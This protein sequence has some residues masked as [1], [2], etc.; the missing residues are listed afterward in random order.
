MADLSELIDAFHAAKV[1]WEA[2]F[3]A[4]CDAA[5]AS[6]E[7]DTYESAENAVIVYPCQ[8]L[9]DVHAK[10]GFFLQ[11]SGPYDTIRNCFGAEEETLRPFL[12]SLL[13]EGSSCA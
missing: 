12:R 8:T 1:A 2:R 10:A 4:D 13:G 7:W 3:E 11:N 5:D 6:P 9:D